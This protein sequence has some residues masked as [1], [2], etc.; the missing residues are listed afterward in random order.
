MTLAQDLIASSRPKELSALELS[1]YEMLLEEQAYPFE[2]T[3]IELHENNAARAFNGLY[4]DF[5]KQSFRVLKGT[6][7]ARYSKQ[8]ITSGVSVNEL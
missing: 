1:Q 5:V 6:L 8:E 4:D 3:A 2:E 7:P